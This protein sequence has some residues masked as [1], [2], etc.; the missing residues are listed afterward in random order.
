MTKDFLLLK[1]TMWNY[2]SCTWSTEKGAQDRY[3]GSVLCAHLA[4][5]FTWMAGLCKAVSH[6]HCYKVQD[7]SLQTKT[8]NSARRLHNRVPKLITHSLRQCWVTELLKAVWE[9][10]FK[11]LSRKNN[12]KTIE[13]GILYYNTISFPLKRVAVISQ[14][15]HAGCHSVLQL[16]RNLVSMILFTTVCCR[17]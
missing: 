4:K 17:V 1:L 13:E 5:P 10:M 3:L 11:T 15:I 6:A 7:A 12:T 16:M 14:W 9:D 8:V 2:K